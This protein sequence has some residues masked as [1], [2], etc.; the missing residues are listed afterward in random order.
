MT[1]IKTTRTTYTLKCP[2]CG[3]NSDPI[4]DITK[5]DDWVIKGDK[6]FHEECT[7]RCKLDGCEAFSLNGDFCSRNHEY[8]HY[9]YSEE[10]EKVLVLNKCIIKE[11]EDKTGWLYIGHY[12]GEET[13]RLLEGEECVISF[14][15]GA[16]K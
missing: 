16:L 6:C 3:F 14:I 5:V 1:I 7:P 4:E 8:K 2:V 10:A 15:N 11:Y 13:Y 9:F 12:R